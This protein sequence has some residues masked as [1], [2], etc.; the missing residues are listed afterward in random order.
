V[1]RIS[2]PEKFGS[3]AKNGLFQHYPPGADVRSPEA[4]ANGPKWSRAA[5]SVLKP[6]NAWLEYYFLVH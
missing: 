6:T 3:S 4:G 2:G 5:A 1:E